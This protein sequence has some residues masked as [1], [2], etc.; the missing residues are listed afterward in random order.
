MA[1]VKVKVFSKDKAPEGAGIALKHRLYVSGWNLSGELVSI[2]NSNDNGKHK[3]SIVYKDDE[4]VAVAILN[5][6]EVQAFV[7][8]SERKQGFGTMAV[9]GL[10][11]PKERD[12][13]YGCGI[14]G[15]Y[16]F[17]NKV[18]EK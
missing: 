11:P 5:N 6:R 2:R 16:K 8:K 18:L 17:W 12:A 14:D 9:K 15:S 7:R 1:N 3:V 10:K 4:P 13:Y